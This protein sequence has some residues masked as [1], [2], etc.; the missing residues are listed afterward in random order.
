MPGQGVTD[1]PRPLGRGA[2]APA[3]ITYCLLF[4]VRAGEPSVR[5]CPHPAAAP[6]V[7]RDDGEV[8]RIGHAVV[9]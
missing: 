1:F 3:P 9:V 8:R 5:E 4:E 2:T 7:W 6:E